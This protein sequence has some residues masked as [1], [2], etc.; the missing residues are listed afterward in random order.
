MKADIEQGLW[1]SKRDNKKKQDKVVTN[2]LLLCSMEE[3][4]SCEF[5][6]YK[7]IANKIG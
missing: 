1:N 6:N 4:K 3:R 5:G 7:M 2:L